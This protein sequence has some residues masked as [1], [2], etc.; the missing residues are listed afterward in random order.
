MYP[1][2]S[3]YIKRVLV[4]VPK[5]VALNWYSEFQKWLYN[6]DIDPELA[7]IDVCISKIWIFKIFEIRNFSL[8]LI[9]FYGQI[10]EGYG[11]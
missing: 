7:T 10:F 11:I 8:S 3:D 1:K 4:I 6:D 2:I 5:N 9:I